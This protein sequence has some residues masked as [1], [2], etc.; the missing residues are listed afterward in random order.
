MMRACE[1]AARLGFGIEARPRR[2]STSW[3]ARSSKASPARLTEELIELLR[4]GHAGP[5]CSGCSTSACSSALLPEA[6]AMVAAGERGLGD[7]GQHPADAR[8]QGRGGR[9]ISDGG[10]ARGAAAAERAAAPLRRRGG[11]AQRALRRA[12]LARAGA[13]G[14]R[15]RSSAASRSRKRA[16]A[17]D[18]PRRSIGFQRLC[19]PRWSAAERV[20]LARTSLLPRR[21][22]ALRAAGARATGEGPRSWRSGR[23]PAPATSGA[24]RAARRGRP[25]RVGARAPSGE[26]PIAAGAGGAP[27]RRG[28]ARACAGRRRRPPACR[29]A[30]SARRRRV[31]KKAVMAVTGVML[32]GF[33]LVHMVGNLKLY[34]GPEKIEPLRASSCARSGAPVFGRGQLAVDRARRAARRGRPAHL[35]G[36]AADPQPRAPRGRWPTQARV[37]CSRPTPRA[38]CAGAA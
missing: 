32:F 24:R 3:R 15:S 10:A 16:H 20:R 28:A 12:E 36:L 2:R 8:S 11:G 29:C 9:E 14:D 35:G 37:R 27:A 4:C 6:Y 1:F 22:L 26:R 31:G 13:R 17:A 21:A 23:R 34:Q 18:R 19:E 30:T 38:P 7:F 5:R 33:V 25:A